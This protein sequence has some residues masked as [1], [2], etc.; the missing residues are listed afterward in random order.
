[1]LGTAFICRISHDIH[2]PRDDAGDE[3]SLNYS[4]E[5]TR[6]QTAR[7]STLTIIL[8]SPSNLPRTSQST[9]PI[10]HRLTPSLTMSMQRNAFHGRQEHSMPCPPPASNQLPTA[11]PSNALS[12]PVVLS[13]AAAMPAHAAGRTAETLLNANI[14][15]SMENRRAMATCR[16]PFPVASLLGEEDHD[17]LDMAR[18]W[19]A[20]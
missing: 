10:M 9:R 6:K 19:G 2:D 11:I 1:L 8:S 13:N 12:P 20:D 4:G 18:V 16:L 15:T 7:A 14:H 3:P 17:G 5:H